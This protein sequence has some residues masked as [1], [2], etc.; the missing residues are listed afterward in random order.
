[1][2]I[3]LFNNCLEGKRALV[4]GASRGLGQAI[5]Q[6]FAA[7]GADVAFN[8]GSDREGAENTER[9]ISA[10]GKQA[11]S[12]QVSVLDA[13]ALSNMAKQIEQDWGG[14]DILV[15]NAGVSQPYPFA[16]LEEEDWDELMD[17]NVKGT[18]LATR[19]VA[20]GMIRRRQGVILNM[21][22]IAG[23][24]MIENTPVHYAT[25]KAAV[26]G[27]TQSL[28]KEL[29]RFGIRVNCLAPGLLEDGMGKNIPEHHLQEYL[30]HNALGRLGKLSEIAECAAFL[31][32]DLN[33]YMNGETIV[34]DG[35]L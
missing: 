32:S 28:S 23:V 15:N 30:F 17:I 19:A 6:T 1:M 14:I 21:S 35:G 9:Q 12:F 13:A 7:C 10:Y 34:I 4:T 20:R 11:K 29:S 3:P 33:S 2:K 24:R 18:Y 8:F 26:K 25:S 22:S 31:V 27:F 16:M 5:C